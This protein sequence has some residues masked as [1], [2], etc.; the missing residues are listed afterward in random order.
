MTDLTEIQVF[1]ITVLIFLLYLLYSLNNQIVNTINNL[2]YTDSSSLPF[3]LLLTKEK[4]NT[5]IVC[6]IGKMKKKYEGKVISLF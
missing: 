4:H 3:S 6:V 5:L 1:I 2:F